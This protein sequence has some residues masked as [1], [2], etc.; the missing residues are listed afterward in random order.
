MRSGFH[1]DS[2]LNFLRE[3]KNICMPNL[4]FSDFIFLDNW[5][6]LWIFWNYNLLYCILSLSACWFLLSIALTFIY[7]HFSHFGYL[8]FN[9]FIWIIPVKLNYN[10]W[11]GMY[12]I[13]VISGRRERMV[14]WFWPSFSILTT[15]PRWLMAASVPKATYW[16]RPSQFPLFPPVAPKL[17]A[18]LSLQLY[19]IS[20]S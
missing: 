9:P 3:M 1:L 18:S 10:N 11:Y 15:L 6:S 17:D 4:R 14:S 19:C 16:E 5:C 13:K 20:D 8:L 12:Y 2:I 7:L